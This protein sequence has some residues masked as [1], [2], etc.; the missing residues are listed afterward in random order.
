MVA[1]R[2]RP[3]IILFGDSLT[4]FSFGDSVVGGGGGVGWASLLSSAYQRRADVFNRGFSGYNTRHA[5]EM[6]P[7]VFAPAE[8][9]I[10]F[11]TV[12]LGANDASLPGERQHVSVEEYSENLSKIIVLIR[13]RTA[14]RKREACGDADFPIIVLTPPPVDNEAWKTWREIDYFDRTNDHTRKYVEEAKKVAEKHN[15]TVL[16][17]WEIL[18]GSSDVAEYG[19][20]LSDGLH[21]SESG[22]RLIFDALIGKIRSDFPHLAPMVDGDEKY[23][24]TGIPVE[25]KLWDE[26]C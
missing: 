23:G 26:L 10:V 4:Q 9:G 21:L 7:K 16:D 25:E 5:L 14:A 24:E 19:K 22:N 13:E 6:V 18:G 12:F 1:F 11:A 3:A 8:G 20:H 15:C 2:V 17:T